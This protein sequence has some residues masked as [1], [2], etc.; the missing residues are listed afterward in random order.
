MTATMARLILTHTFPRSSAAF[1]AI[2]RRSAATISTA[3]RLFGEQH[4]G[5][6]ERHCQRGG[7]EP[8]HGVSDAMSRLVNRA[9]R[10][11]AKG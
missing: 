9:R 3:G 4:A 7:G 6:H 8:L 11:S 1:L 2:L 10:G 5:C